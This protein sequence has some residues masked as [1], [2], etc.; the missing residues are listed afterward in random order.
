MIGRGVRRSETEVGESCRSGACIPICISNDPIV[1]RLHSNEMLY[2]HSRVMTRFRASRAKGDA[3]AEKKSACVRACVRKLQAHDR[4]SADRES[5]MRWIMT[6][7][8]GRS[9]IVRAPSGDKAPATWK[10]CARDAF[11]V[12]ATGSRL[13]RHERKIIAS[14][15]GDGGV[16]VRRARHT[17]RHASSSPPAPSG[18]FAVSVRLMALFGS[19]NEVTRSTSMKSDSSLQ[20]FV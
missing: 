5:P 20:L 11:D 14:P 3:A 13:M 10:V 1:L 15:P 9:R 19:K 17:L 4:P 18:T 8:R 2:A 6:G 12:A 7:A 16:H